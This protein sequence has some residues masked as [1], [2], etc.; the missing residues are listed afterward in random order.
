MLQLIYQIIIIEKKVV[1]SSIKSFGEIE[2]ILQTTTA[3][4]TYKTNTNNTNTR[5]NTVKHLLKLENKTN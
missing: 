5:T 3:T 1:G 2:H 4:D